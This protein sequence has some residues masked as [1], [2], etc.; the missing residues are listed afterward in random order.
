MDGNSELKKDTRNNM[1]PHVFLTGKPGKW[2]MATKPV[3]SVHPHSRK[4]LVEQVIDAGPGMTYTTN[5]CQHGN[6]KLGSFMLSRGCRRSLMTV[7]KF[8]CSFVVDARN[9]SKTL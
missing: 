5:I 6:R 4:E 3:S 7:R 8:L 9:G 1:M 2:K